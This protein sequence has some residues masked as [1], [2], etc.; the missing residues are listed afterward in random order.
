MAANGSDIVVSESE[1]HSRFVDL[2]QTHFIQRSSQP[3][4]PDATSGNVKKVPVLTLKEEDMFTVP[5]GV[6]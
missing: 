4:K 6:C 1:I 5:D 3:T 2:V